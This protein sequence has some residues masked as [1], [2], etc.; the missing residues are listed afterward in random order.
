MDHNIEIQKKN[1]EKMALI[2]HKEDYEKEYILFDVLK[3]F[4]KVFSGSQGGLES[5]SSTIERVFTIKKNNSSNFMKDLEDKWNLI[6]NNVLT[7]KTLAFYCKKYHEKEYI[8]FMKENWVG[9]VLNSSLSGEDDNIAEA[10]CTFLWLDIVYDPEKKIIYKYNGTF[11]EKCYTEY[12]K[13][14]VSRNFRKIYEKIRENLYKTGEDSL[15]SDLKE[16]VTETIKRVSKVITI[17]SSS[18]KKAQIINECLAKLSL[19]M[20]N[21]FDKNPFS[22]GCSN[23][24]I[25]VN[26]STGK[27]C[28]R[29]GKPEDYIKKS[30]KVIF[31]STL[32]WKNPIV[33][34]F[35]KWMDKIYIEKDVKEF[36]YKIFS[37]LLMDGNNDKQFYLHVGESGNNGKSTL[38][39]TI[40]AALGDDHCKMHP[41]LLTRDYSSSDSASPAWTRLQGPRLVSCEEINSTSKLQNG[42]LKLLTGN[43]SF[44]G[45]NLYSD[46]EDHQTTC[47]PF[48]YTNKS[49]GV[50][51]LDNALKRRIIV[52]PYKSQWRPDAPDDEKKQFETRIF[53]IDPSFTNNLER[54]GP[55][56]LWIA[57]QFFER[58]AKEKLDNKPHKVEK[59]TKSYFKE[60]DIF[61]MFVDEKIEKTD[62]KQN[63][64]IISLPIQSAYEE[65]TLWYSRVFKGKIDYPDR[66]TFRFHLTQKLKKTR[67]NAWGGYKIIKDTNS[68][69]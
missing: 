11:W 40:S 60:F 2:L 28:I 16:R 44:F 58:Y 68:D 62:K 3:V 22:T 30:T 31:D 39:N 51:E 6:K 27:Y 56:I 64:K 23:K 61:Q 54:F 69:Q 47:V 45:R 15:D 18:N 32:T 35:D 5:F 66:A 55:V 19:N 8:L 57:C 1:I 43:D 4:H 34:E 48:M 50:N 24:I 26:R 63:G 7:I 53:K 42:P 49:P 10:L 36:L 37:S 41:S 29:D 13:N 17:L 52:I 59:A 67:N 46:G 20:E 12:I 14:D 33:I 65:F 9:D 21:I 25:E 38:Q